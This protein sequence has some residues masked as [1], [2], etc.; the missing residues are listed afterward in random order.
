MLPKRAAKR[1]PGIAQTHLKMLNILAHSHLI[2]LHVPYIFF[3][4]IADYQAICGKG[5]I[6][7]QEQFSPL[8][9]V[10]RGL[11]LTAFHDGKLPWLTPREE[12]R[13]V[14]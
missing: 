14:K 9:S 13:G 2:P 5:A 4:I 1:S 10:T 3:I 7:R 6:C 12:R 11:P 8:K